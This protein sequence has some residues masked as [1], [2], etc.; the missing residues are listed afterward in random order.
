MSLLPLS[1]FHCT[2]FR[3]P[4]FLYFPCLFSPFPTSLVPT[5]IVSNSLTLLPLP[6]LP[7]SLLLLPLLP[8]SLLPLSL[9]HLSLLPLSLLSLSLIPMSFKLIFL[10][11]L[12]HFQ[13]SLLSFS[14]FSLVHLKK[15]F[16]P[17]WVF[18]PCTACTTI[19]VFYLTRCEDWTAMEDSSQESFQGSQF[20]ILHK[21]C[22]Y[23]VSLIP[24]AGK[25]YKMKAHNPLYPSSYKPLYISPTFS[26]IQCQKNFLERP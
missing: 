21:G 7:L 19:P 2:Y 6:L 3:C 5:S 15:E 11:S 16:N 14:I 8:M 17:S 4:Y 13:L 24:L 9:L 1:L 22:D 25:Q 26:T 23:G 18:K 10:L 12:S 20:P